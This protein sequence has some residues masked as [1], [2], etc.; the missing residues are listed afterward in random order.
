MKEARVRQRLEMILAG[1]ILAALVFTAKLPTL[2]L[3]FYWDEVAHVIPLSVHVLKN[4]FSPIL[5]MP[6][7]DRSR[8]NFYG[9]IQDPGHP[10][11]VFLL[12]AL[13]FKIFGVSLATAHSLNMIFCWMAIFFTYAFARR[14]FGRGQAIGAALT[15]FT[16]PLFF[17]VSGTVHLTMATTAFTAASIYFAVARREAPFA[18]TA[19]CMMLT[20][21]NGFLAYPGMLAYLFYSLW[22]GKWKSTLKKLLPYL[23][24]VAVYAAWMVFHYAETGYV[25]LQ[26]TNY[27]NVLPHKGFDTFFWGLLRVIYIFFFLRGGFFLSLIVILFLASYLKNR[28]PALRKKGERLRFLKADLDAH[29]EIVLF[30]LIPL[31]YMGAFSTLQNLSAQYLLPTSPLLVVAGI[32]GLFYLFR[33]QRLAAWILTGLIVIFQVACW[34]GDDPLVAA[35][36]A[37]KPD[38]AEKNRM[39]FVSYENNLEYIDVIRLHRE[40]ARYLEGNF[41]DKKI[42]AGW[43][44]IIEL[45]YP[46][47]GYVQKPLELI[48]IGHY[49]KKPDPRSF[50]VLVYATEANGQRA[51]QKILQTQ[52]L[53]LVKTFRKG[54]KAVYI[55]VNLPAAGG[56]ETRFTPSGTS[57]I[58]AR[59]RDLP[60]S[61]SGIHS[62]LFP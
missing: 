61:P 11:L 22:D 16:S 5:E 14:L 48:Y 6:E 26:P 20:R 46:Y 49:V 1:L 35:V 10:P 42:L 39:D 58:S 36:V 19:S 57:S 51:I 2:R 24:P 8:E 53:E 56:G 18:V 38:I 7:G 52:K 17:A 33:S 41:S 37:L 45:S 21:A 60:S 32:A 44:L 31:S 55:F 47:L 29:K 34:R 28:L 3:P 13:A 23:I 15:L 40:A 54:A 50:D 9:L 30:I 27:F 62:T 25:L 4:N 59:G 43:P 12:I